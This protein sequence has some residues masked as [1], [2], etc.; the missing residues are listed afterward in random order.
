MQV[1]GRGRGLEHRFQVMLSG[2]LIS[3][4]RIGRGP[5]TIS[6]ASKYTTRHSAQGQVHFINAR[7]Q[8]GCRGRLAGHMAPLLAISS[9][10]GRPPQVR[11]QVPSRA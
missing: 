3:L 10:L 2:R 4:R 11:C 1:K 5:E 7:L 8:P 9:S 6:A